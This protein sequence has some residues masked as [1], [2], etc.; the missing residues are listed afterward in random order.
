MNAAPGDSTGTLEHDPLSAT[1]DMLTTLP[2]TLGASGVAQNV[3]HASLTGNLAELIPHLD[4]LRS[5]HSRL[6]AESNPDYWFEQGTGDDLD[7]V[8]LAADVAAE[9]RH[10]AVMVG[11]VVLQVA[12]LSE[13][14]VS[15]A[16]SSFAVG[17]R[18]G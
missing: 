6:L 8:T 5:L 14:E 9:R 13:T 11:S 17:E 3:R 7:A 4:G 1:A 15:E 2:A 18:V 12:E 16:D 10:Q